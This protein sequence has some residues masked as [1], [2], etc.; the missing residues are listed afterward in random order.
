MRRIYVSLVL[1]GSLM[2]PACGEK[3]ET[4]SRHSPEAIH[5]GDECHV[6]GMTV[7]RFPGPKGQAFVRHRQHS[8]KFC[9]T[10]DLFS[11]LLQP[12]TKA[13]AEDVYVHD[14]ASTDWDKPGDDAFIDATTAWYVIGHDRRGAMGPTLA[15]FHDRSAADEFATRHGGQVLPFKEVDLD[16]LMRSA[17]P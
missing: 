1:L 17:N 8:F 9:S 16:V 14:M 5:A 6:C 11:W 4:V 15:S 7:A 12:E 13:I 2:L 10:H 3:P